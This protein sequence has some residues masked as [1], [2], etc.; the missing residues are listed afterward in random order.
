MQITPRGNPADA[1]AWSQ[2]L[3][4]GAAEQ[5]A[6]IVII[7]FDGARSW[8]AVG[9]LAVDV[10]LDDGHVVALSQG[11]QGTLVGLRHD[12]TQWVVARRGELDGLDRPLL[13]G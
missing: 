12:V 5:H 11:Q 7:G 2:G 4:E 10:V 8:V 3:G 13:Q 9:Q 6:T 1:Q